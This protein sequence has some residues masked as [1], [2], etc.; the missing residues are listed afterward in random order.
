MKKL[1]TYLIVLSLIMASCGNKKKE[2]EQKILEAKNKVITEVV[3]VGRIEPEREI[4]Q[5]STENSGIIA[6][7][8]KQENDSV[9]AGE[10]I[11]IL[12]TALENAELNQAK[13]KLQTFKKQLQVTCYRLQAGSGRNKS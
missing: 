13:S 12:D 11:A 9:K 2:E 8:L 1:N 7:I 3:G 6:I 5:L 4:I 10:T